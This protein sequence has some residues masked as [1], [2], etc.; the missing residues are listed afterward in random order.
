MCCLI[1]NESTSCISEEQSPSHLPCKYNLHDYARAS[2][3]MTSSVFGLL[4]S[5]LN[6]I[7]NAFNFKD[8]GGFSYRAIIIE[9]S[10]GDLMC[11]SS[12]LIISIASI[13][14]GTGYFENEYYWERNFVCFFSATLII[15]YTVVSSAD[16]NLL[17]ISRLSV[18]KYPFESRFTDNA[19]FKFLG[20]L[21]LGFNILALVVSL[22]LV[23]CQWITVG[24]LP[25]GL[26]TLLGNGTF[27]SLFTTFVTILLH[28]ISMF[29]LPII[30]YKIFSIW[31]TSSMPTNNR[32]RK[33]KEGVKLRQ[34]ITSVMMEIYCLTNVTLLLLILF[35]HNHSY[36]I[37]TWFAGVILPINS[38]IN[39]FLF[40]FGR[41]ACK[42]C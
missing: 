21:I 39:P 7:A 38:L 12:S 2:L 41:I 1:P 5:I 9:I 14:Y 25:N 29:S 13:G 17:P 20:R 15:I 3:V 4:L 28:I 37:F 8:L 24:K 27:I 34:I 22:V 40:T 26:C 31:Q 42:I 23:I 18:T 35:L 16:H 32:N 30:Y 36:E 10:V 33:L 11:S 6:I 19:D